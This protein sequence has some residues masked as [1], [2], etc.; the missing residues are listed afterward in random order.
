MAI[1][2]RA[3]ACTE[4]EK[5]K[6]EA[7]LDTGA[8][9]L[10]SPS[11]RL[12][13]KVV[14]HHIQGLVSDVRLEAC[15]APLFGFDVLILF[16]VLVSMVDLVVRV[17]AAVVGGLCCR[18][19]LDGALFRLF[20]FLLQLRDRRRRDRR[21]R[22]GLPRLRHEGVAPKAR[23]LPS[24]VRG[25]RRLHHLIPFGTPVLGAVPGK[26]A[27]ALGRGQRV[28]AVRAALGRKA[29]ASLRAGVVIAAQIGSDGASLVPPD[30]VHTARR[31]LG[32][33]AADDVIV[34][35]VEGVVVPNLVADMRVAERGLGS[36][37]HAVR[38]VR[39]PEKRDGHLEQ[40]VESLGEGLVADPRRLEVVRSLHIV[41]RLCL[42]AEHSQ[43]RQGAPVGMPRHEHRRARLTLRVLEV[44]QKLL[45]QAFP[46]FL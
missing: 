46:D 29:C 38:A 37:G 23:L 15:V 36:A 17:V 35:G 45:S 20:L 4:P 39:D 28:L 26:V 43:R 7:T 19:L 2:R 12:R 31:V 21:G 5:R 32:R 18:E 11:V 6:V 8:P 22:D 41:A 33:V 13:G 40:P 16:L 24:R 42:Q 25:A 27:E 14:A 3:A 9:Q 10:A 44:V 1:A 30:P 34:R